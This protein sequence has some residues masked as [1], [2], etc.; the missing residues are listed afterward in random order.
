[1]APLDSGQ[2]LVLR[3]LP[4]DGRWVR[5][6]ELPLPALYSTTVR[7]A[8]VLGKLAKRGLVESNSRGRGSREKTLFRITAEGIR[9]LK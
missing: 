9:A 6:D 7:L 8:G 4:Q 5:A 1:M 2:K 3:I